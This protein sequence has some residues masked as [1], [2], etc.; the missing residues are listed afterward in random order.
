AI[1]CELSLDKMNAFKEAVNSYAL[2]RL[3]DDVL[4]RRIKIDSKIDFNSINFSFLDAFSLLSPF[5][6][7]N[8]KP[9]FV[10]EA[11]QVVAEPKKLQG[12]HCKLLVRQNG[13]YFEALAWGRGD[14]ADSIQKGDIINLCYS[15]QFSEYLGEEK[16][17]L[18]LIDIKK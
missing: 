10:T 13:K 8:P 3:T 16:L 5:G 2:S 7:G 11:V 9:V 18:N 14:W 6:A 1:G 12:K 4:R 15:L 17:N